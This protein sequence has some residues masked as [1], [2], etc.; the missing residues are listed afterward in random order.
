MGLRKRFEQ[1]K[2]WIA[3][4]VGLFSSKICLVYMEADVLQQ[5]QTTHYRVQNDDKEN[6]NVECYS[7]QV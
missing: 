7:S 4:K 6:L 5:W 2:D 1:K 3:E